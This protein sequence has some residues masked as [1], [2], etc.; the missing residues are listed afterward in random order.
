MIIFRKDWKEARRNWQI[1]LPML[2]L[3]IVFAIVLP[4]SMSA[5]LTS[6][7]ITKNQTFVN[8][9]EIAAATA[10]MT[11]GQAIAYTMLVFLFAP[12]FLIIPLMTSSVIAADSFAGEKERK[13]TE[14][15]LATPITDSELF[16]GKILV[17]FVPAIIATIV[18]FVLYATIVNSLFLAHAGVLVLPTVSWLLLVFVLAPVVALAGIGI[19]VLVSARVKG[20]REAQQISAMMVFPVVLLLV[21]QLSGVLFLGAKNIL[22]IALVLFI[23]AYAILRLGIRMFNREALLARL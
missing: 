22:I 11:P 7:D 6:T 4:L 18:S 21:G 19:T 17:A 12:F 1:F 3:P 8:N 23:V 9:P 5:S 20:F 16:F 10:G 15:L 13:T 14:A 2:I